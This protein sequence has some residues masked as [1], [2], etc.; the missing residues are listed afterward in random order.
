LTIK[1]TLTSPLAFYHFLKVALV[2]FIFAKFLNK[3]FL[4]KNLTKIKSRKIN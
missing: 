2:D 3:D 4:A 1:N